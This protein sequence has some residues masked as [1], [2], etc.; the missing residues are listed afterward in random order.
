V[1]TARSLAGANG[2]L[3]DFFAEII[4]MVLGVIFKHSLSGFWTRFFSKKRKGK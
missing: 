4:L 2:I 3:P 1:E